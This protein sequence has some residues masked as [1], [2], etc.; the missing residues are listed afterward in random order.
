[1]KHLN[2]STSKP[3]LGRGERVDP[4]TGMTRSS[5]DL[6]VNWIRKAVKLVNGMITR[7]GGR[8]LINLFKKLGGPVTKVSRS[9]VK[10]YK[11]Y[12]AF[13]FNLYRKGGLKYVCI[14]LKAC[15]VLLQQ[16]VGGQRIPSTR[17]LNAAVSRTKSGLPRVIPALMRA[18]I[19]NREARVIRLWL[20]LFNLYRIVEFPGKLKLQTITDP[21]TA[22]QDVVDDFCRYVGEC[23]YPLLLK[24]NNPAKLFNPSRIKITLRAIPFL[25]SKSSPVFARD[26]HLDGE[27]LS[28]SSP[29]GIL[30]AAA[31]LR[32]DPVL[33]GPLA[34]WFEETDNLWASNLIERWSPLIDSSRLSGSTGALGLKE[35][36]AGKIRVFAM[37]DIFTQWMFNPLHKRI[38]SILREIRQ[39]G[40][41]DQTRPVHRMF[42]TMEERN[43]SK[44]YSFDLS[45]A[46]D[47]LPIVIQQFLLSLFIGKEL[48]EI[49]KSLLIFRGYHLRKLKTTLYY[50]TGQ[51]MGAL[52]SWVML[53]ITHHAI[54]Q[55]AAYI[56]RGRQNPWIWFKLY[57]VLGDDVCIADERVAKTYV[58]VMQSLG[59][60]ISLAKSL[61]SSHRTAEFAKRF[62]IP[63]DC[64]P[65]SFRELLCAERNAQSL[66]EYVK[67]FHLTLPDALD[68]MGFGWRVKSQIHKPFSKLG[69]RVRR[70]L[71]LL[72]SPE[73]A[74]PRELTEWL[75]M[76][77]LVKTNDQAEWDRIYDSYLSRSYPALLQKIKSLRKKLSRWADLVEHFMAWQ[78]ID[79]PK[80]GTPTLLLAHP[81]SVVTEEGTSDPSEGPIR[82]DT[83]QEEV[84]R[85]RLRFFKEIVSEY[86]S[87]PITKTTISSPAA[88]SKKIRSSS[89]LRR[90]FFKEVV[91][92]L[93]WSI[94][95]YLWRIPW[96]P[97]VSRVDQIR[98]FMDMI[99]VIY[100]PIIEA[101]LTDLERLKEV[102]NLFNTPYS[103]E[104]GE[105]D[106]DLALQ[107]LV[108]D[109]G[110]TMPSSNPID[111]AEFLWKVFDHIE[112]EVGLVPSSDLVRRTVSKETNS[113]LPKVR[114]WHYLNGISFRRRKRNIS[115]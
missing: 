77:S 75:T 66:V 86:R 113:S 100:T 80:S 43:L 46:T 5:Q 79:V 112:E 105:S 109:L 38:Q 94:S 35:E 22:R 34:K 98:V 96:K 10:V 110:M 56:A 63:E 28:S 53:A 4:R 9:W 18:R 88:L 40:T 2:Q 92:R 78:I 39:D 93:D 72:T 91:G 24:I 27:S 108:T 11:A 104:L 103:E 14:Y 19:M 74:F 31:F 111:R 61:E 33:W 6:D 106:R 57:S 102:V 65:I 37:V 44:V 15:S 51:P 52:S 32:K 76:R 21:S 42:K 95:E 54:V 55:Y 85:L 64:S 50:A 84:E 73:G 67:R 107:K 3:R 90:N 99:R 49:W 16:A 115:K 83:P 82:R 41:F 17:P 89:G 71:V 12:G 20:S 13:I 58:R 114:M 68:I 59:V 48:A 26:D 87:I 30:K 62:W 70:L 60:E 23:F 25:I 81:N 7:N 47:R 97:T 29:L 69:G 45:A 8:S 1:M 36:P 101:S